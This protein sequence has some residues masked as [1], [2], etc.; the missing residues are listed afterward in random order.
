[1]CEPLKAAGKVLSASAS[2]SGSLSLSDI[3]GRKPIA[4]PDPDPDADAEFDA[5]VSMQYV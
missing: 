3:G 1:L 2:V 5:P 4:I